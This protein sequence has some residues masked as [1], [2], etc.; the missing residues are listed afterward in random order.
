MTSKPRRPCGK[1][2]CRNLTTE[3]YCADHAHLVEQQRKERH[4]HYDRHQRDK[5]A[6][7]F[8]KSI[9]WLR[10]RQ[11]ALIRDHGLCQDCLEHKHITPATEVDHII[12]IRVRWD[13]R[14]VLSNLRSLCHRCHMIKTAE[15]KRRY[16]G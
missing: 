2:G 14:L 15:D 16:G 4:R 6:A 12:P 3:R 7:V 11:Q 5:Q 8:Y 13:L 10:V 1:I 9:E